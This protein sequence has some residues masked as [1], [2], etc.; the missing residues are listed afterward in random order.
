M[1]QDL[2]SDLYSK[3]RPEDFQATLHKLADIANEETSDLLEAR[4]K[5]QQAYLTLCNE[6]NRQ[7]EE[8]WIEA[9]DRVLPTLEP[10]CPPPNQ[11][12]GHHTNS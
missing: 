4:Y 7:W 3:V 2:F 12:S 1:R 9:R 6:Y 5:A 8:V 10:Q 11:Q